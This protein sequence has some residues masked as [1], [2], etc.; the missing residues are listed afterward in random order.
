MF[1]IEGQSQ[2][3]LI[4]SGTENDLNSIQILNDEIYIPSKIMSL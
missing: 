2:F 1:Y 4:P 3:E